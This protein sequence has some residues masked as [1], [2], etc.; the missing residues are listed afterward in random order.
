MVMTVC[1]PRPGPG[2]AVCGNFCRPQSSDEDVKPGSE[3]RTTSKPKSG[4][5]VKDAPV[6][7][8][9]ST[10]EASEV[11]AESDAPARKSTPASRKKRVGRERRDA[12]P[13]K[14][15]LISLVCSYIGH[16]DQA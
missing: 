8:A 6:S 2:N 11:D 3:T 16:R 10:N 7:A 1:L 15:T 5:K 13:R 9:D 14:I 12:S 4:E